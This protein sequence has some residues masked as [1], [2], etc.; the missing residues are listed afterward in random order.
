MWLRLPGQS[1][2]YILR[3]LFNL[4]KPGLFPYTAEALGYPIGASGARFLTT[5]LHG[6]RAASLNKEIAT[7]CIGGG[8]GSVPAVQRP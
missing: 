8:Q 7:L 5:L 4:T 3:P 6:K 1:S 2:L